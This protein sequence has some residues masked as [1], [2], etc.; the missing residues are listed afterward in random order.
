MS[1]IFKK[2]D[3]EDLFIVLLGIGFM[4][5]LIICAFNLSHDFNE[6]ECVRFYKKNHY[7][8]NDCKRYANKLEALDL[9]EK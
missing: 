7:I 6:R 1:E 2:F 3:S 8:T 5:S 9:N 4:I